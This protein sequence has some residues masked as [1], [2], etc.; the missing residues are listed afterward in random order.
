M[1]TYTVCA[2]YQV[3]F[4]F[5]GT[6]CPIGVQCCNEIQNGIITII[7]L[8]IHFL[9]YNWQTRS[10]GYVETKQYNFTIKSYSKSPELDL[11]T[12]LF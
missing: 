7:K 10:K 12:T 11:E 4:Y 8:S 6:R 9:G 5:W 2:Y 1:H 3:L